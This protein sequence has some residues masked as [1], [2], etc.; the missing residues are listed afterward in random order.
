MRLW[1]VGAYVRALTWTRVNDQ[2]A[3]SRLDAMSHARQSVAGEG[4]FIRIKPL[5][6]V[7]DFDDD[8]VIVI[9]Q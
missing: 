9:A 8:L 4:N 2:M 1:Q 5:P 7:A 3:A 6:V